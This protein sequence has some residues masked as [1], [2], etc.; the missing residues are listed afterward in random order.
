V[1][2]RRVAL[3]SNAEA[4]FSTHE[5]AYALAFDALGLRRETR[6]AGGQLMNQS[7]AQLTGGVKTVSIRV[8]K[9]E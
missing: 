4:A 1:I 3:P 7:I 9:T 2:W 6:R 8:E 5:R